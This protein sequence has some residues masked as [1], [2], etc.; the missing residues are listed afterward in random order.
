MNCQKIKENGFKLL[1]R[2]SVQKVLKFLEIFETIQKSPY[3][4]DFL[5]DHI[6]KDNINILKIQFEFEFSYIYKKY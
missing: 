3:L 1:E 5:K 4:K 6:Q 2:L